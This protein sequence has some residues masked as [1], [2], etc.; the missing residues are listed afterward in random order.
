MILAAGALDI[1]E[2]AA[3]LAWLAHRS[4]G[5]AMAAATVAAVAKWLLILFAPLAAAVKL[6]RSIRVSVAARSSPAPG[7]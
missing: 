6:Y 7:S 1:V 5:F 2:N 3:M 4:S